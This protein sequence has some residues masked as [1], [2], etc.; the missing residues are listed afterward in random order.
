M[1]QV[2]YPKCYICLIS[3]ELDRLIGTWYCFENK[4]ALLFELATFSIYDG[5]LVELGYKKIIKKVKQ[6][7]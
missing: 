1:S 7:S 2:L 4:F 3:L 5:V 6:K